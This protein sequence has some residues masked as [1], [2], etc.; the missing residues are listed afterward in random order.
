MSKPKRVLSLAP[1][2]LLVFMDNQRTYGRCARN[3]L[4]GGSGPGGGG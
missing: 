1:A 4:R 2:R 3:G